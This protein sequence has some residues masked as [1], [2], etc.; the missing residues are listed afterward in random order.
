METRLG[1]LIA[2]P[3]VQAVLPNLDRSMSP[4]ACRDIVG[5]PELR[6]KS[7][8]RTIAIELYHHEKNSKIWMSNVSPMAISVVSFSL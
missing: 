1:K 6:V 3:S 5:W 8:L 2:R 7:V 4:A